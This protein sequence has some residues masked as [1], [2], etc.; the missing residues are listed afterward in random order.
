MFLSW[1]PTGRCLFRVWAYIQGFYA[2]CM[3]TY[4]IL[5]PFCN[6]YIIRV[7]TLIILVKY[8]PCRH[9]TEFLR[10]H[11]TKYQWQWGSNVVCQQEAMNIR[12]AM[13]VNNVHHP[14]QSMCLFKMCRHTNKI[15]RELLI[16][17]FYFQPITTEICLIAAL[18]FF[19]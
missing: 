9:R 16:L 6:N 12:M 5:R 7:F 2:G 3:P 14:Q 8:R 11:Y 1:V 4:I 19:G 18:F 17:L 15:T 13:N 10:R